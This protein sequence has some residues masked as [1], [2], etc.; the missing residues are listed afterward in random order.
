MLIATPARRLA[1]LLTLVLPFSLAARADEVSHRAKAQEMMTLLH[2]QRLVQSISDNIK[3]QIVEAAGSITGPTPTPDQEAKAADFEKQASQ[4]IDAQ[5]SWNSMKTEFTDI[6]AKAFTEEQLDGII[7]FY[8][9]PAGVAL[10]DNMPA[11][12]TQV[13]QFGTSHMTALQPRLKDLFDNFRKSVTAAASAPSLGAPDAA[14][15]PLSATHP[16]NTPK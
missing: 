12:N 6:Y 11:V 2:T 8:K 15:A 10:L 5:L 3:K 14:P 9:T 13:Q 4:L 16:P 7:A 1:L